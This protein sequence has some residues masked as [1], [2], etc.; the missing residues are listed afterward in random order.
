MI[1]FADDTNLFFLNNSLENLFQIANT[2]L[3]N[4]SKWFKLN[5]L[6][7]N[8]KNELL[9][10]SKAKKLSS[11]FCITINNNI[12]EQVVSTTFLGVVINQSLTWFD[13]I[14]TGKQKANKSIGILYRVKKNM[15]CLF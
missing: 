6:S 5:K 15:P 10:G 8:I 4:M 2:E 12:I 11:N 9:C 14:K 7:L 3:E 13:H 1:M